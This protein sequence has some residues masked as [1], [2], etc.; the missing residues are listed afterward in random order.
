MAEPPKVFKDSTPKAAPGPGSYNSIAAQYA[1][2]KAAKER[3]DEKKVGGIL[4][5]FGL[6]VGN[7]G[8]GGFRR[9]K[10][11]QK[12]TFERLN[13][14]K[15]LRFKGEWGWIWGFWIWVL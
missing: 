3:E 10:T 9:G 12:G 8:D 6:G 15:E 5:S 14:A 1:R 7:A 11:E 2:A 4:S 13:E